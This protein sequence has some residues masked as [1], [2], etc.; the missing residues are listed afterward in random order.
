MQMI[1]HFPGF[2]QALQS[3][4]MGLEKFDGHK[5]PLLNEISWFVMQ[6]CST[7]EYNISP[8]NRLITVQITLLYTCIENALFLN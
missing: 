7:C 2:A 6:M 3:N 8:H 4:L 1:A 5:L